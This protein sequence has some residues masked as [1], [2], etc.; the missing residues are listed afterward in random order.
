MRILGID[1]G[2][3]HLKAAIVDS[4]GKLLT[5]V[6]KVPT[7]KECTP[8]QMVSQLCRLVKPLGIFDRIAVGFPGMV[9]D[10][11]VITAPHWPSPRWRHFPLAAML[12][13][14]L[15]APVRMIND[16][17]MQGM[18]V[19]KGK[20]LEFVL[21]LGTGAGTAWFRDGV[22]L[23]HMEFAHHP[24]RKKSTY[25]DYLGAKGLQRS[26]RKRWNKHVAWA[27][28][29]LESLLHFDHLFIGGGNAKKVTID[30]GSSTTLV[31]NVAG[32]EGGARLWRESGAPEA[33][34]VLPK[35]SKTV[36]PAVKTRGRARSGA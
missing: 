13:D 16:A 20:G 34:Q 25:E 1:I 8:S 23:P 22:L 9:R 24:L 26:G 11:V 2:G 17:D 5:K 30:L 7:P 12:A 31:A 28:G 14:R 19:I 4:S 33:S 18:A 10:H 36:R 35:T 27:V 21:T 32:I 3:T 6:V 29:V 15:N